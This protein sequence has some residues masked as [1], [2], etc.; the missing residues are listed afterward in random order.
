MLGSG[1]VEAIAIANAEFGTE[2]SE[3][4]TVAPKV[5]YSP[6]VPSR[7]VTNTFEPTSQC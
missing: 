7:L 2:I 6:I 1:T 3:A 5:V 4:L